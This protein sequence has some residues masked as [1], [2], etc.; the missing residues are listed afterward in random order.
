MV[1]D[2]LGYNPPRPVSELLP[3]IDQAWRRFHEVLE[4][5]PL[6]LIEMPGVCDQ[7][8]IKDLIGHVA[9]WDGQVIDDIDGYIACRPS[10][11][12]PWNEWNAD[13][14][15]KRANTSLEDLRAELEATHERMLA[16]LSGVT[17]IDPKMI[18]DDTW[19]HYQEHTEQIERWLM[20]ANR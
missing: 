19:E 13:E 14:A 4:R 10:L 18:A 8:S 20:T 17:E 9:F 2:E 5:V 12:N 3:A 1:E 15:A 11:K 6:D 7:W 16:R